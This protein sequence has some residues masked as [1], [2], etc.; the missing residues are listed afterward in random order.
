MVIDIILNAQNN[1]SLLQRSL[2]KKNSYYL[3]FG[4]KKDVFC[5][6]K[7]INIKILA[8]AQEDHSEVQKPHSQLRF[9]L[10]SIIITITSNEP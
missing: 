10:P 2:R 1:F 6:S 8:F 9:L 4:G 5:F 3:V 7:I